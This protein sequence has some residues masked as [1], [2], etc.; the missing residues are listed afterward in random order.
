MRWL[1]RLWVNKSEYPLAITAAISPHPV[2]CQYYYYYPAT[3]PGKSPGTPSARTTPATRN[4][5]A[6]PRDSTAAMTPSAVPQPPIVALLAHS[7]S[8]IHNYT[9]QPTLR[10]VYRSTGMKR[11]PALCHAMQCVVCT[12]HPPR[13][14]LTSFPLTVPRLPVRLYIFAIAYERTIPLACTPRVYLSHV[15]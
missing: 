10:L 14:R 12:Y 2:R 8:C 5:T 7:S 15:P 9:I 13:S 1:A 4:A 11:R 6:D 3:G